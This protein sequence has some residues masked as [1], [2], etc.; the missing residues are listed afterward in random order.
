MAK[1]RKQIKLG[2]VGFPTRL[3]DLHRSNPFWSGDESG[4]GAG[5]GTGIGIGLGMFEEGI[6]E[7]WSVLFHLNS[8]SP[9]F[10]ISCSSSDQAI[11]RREE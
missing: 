5:A 7:A 11:K 1:S 6:P 2:R 3:L 8:F 10:L 4:V 9:R